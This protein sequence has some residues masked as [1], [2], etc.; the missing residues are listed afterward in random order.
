MPL[1]VN[2]LI[3]VEENNYLIKHHYHC[4]TNVYLGDIRH[5]ISLSLFNLDSNQIIDKILE[6]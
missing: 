2:D 1:N 4:L 6:F 3:K 5:K